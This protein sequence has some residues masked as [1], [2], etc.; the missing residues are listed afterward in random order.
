VCYYGRI[1]SNDDG[2][3]GAIY[4]VSQKREMTPAVKW[5]IQKTPIW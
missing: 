2:D 1:V 4:T 3:S 5:P